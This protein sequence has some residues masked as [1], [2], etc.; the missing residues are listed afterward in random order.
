MG[1][2][3][4]CFERRI[5]ELNIDENDKEKQNKFAHHKGIPPM[6]GLVKSLSDNL[7][8]NFKKYSISI[9]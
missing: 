1:W 6:L 9:F 4:L 3:Q 5:P 7:V 8:N 2:C